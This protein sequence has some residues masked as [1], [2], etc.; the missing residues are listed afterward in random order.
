MTTATEVFHPVL[1][2]A[3][4]GRDDGPGPEHRLWYTEISPL[5]EPDVAAPGVALIG[6]SSDEGIRRN[7]GRPGAA[8]GPESI[9]SKLGWM[10]LHDST[11]RYDAGTVSVTGTDLEAAQG[12]LSTAV[13]RLIAAGHLPIVIGGGH[14][15]AFGSHSGLRRG[16]G[17][18]HRAPGIINLDAHLDLRQ[19]EQAN[20]GTPFRQ[21]ADVVGDDFDYSVIGASA[22][23]NTDFL[24]DA[25]QQFG[26]NVV[27]DHELDS[28]SSEEAAGRARQ[29]IS[30]RDSIHL[31]ID[32]D[33]LNQALAPGV[34][35]PASFGVDLATIRA[36][37]LAIARSGKLRLLDV[38]ELSP[39]L[40]IDGRTARVASRLIQ[41]ISQAHVEAHAA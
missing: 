38:V 21:I 29:W 23:D 11:P 13:H 26:V 39:P 31:S 25:A 17:K 32:L 18:G 20:N 24:F 35:S 5:P 22:A 12:E 16:L 4:T 36:I 28:W 37:C 2:D 1:S 10:A 7:H 41:E 34:T 14:D 33:V 27:Q 40:D 6:F 3:W 8:E 19:S 30:G 9:R 15:A